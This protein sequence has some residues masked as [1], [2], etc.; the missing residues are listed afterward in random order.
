M[1]ARQQKTERNGAG[2]KP[3]RH[4]VFEPSPRWVRV[5]FNGEFVADSKQVMLLHEQGHLPVYYFPRGDVRMDLLTP[6]DHTT[7]CP[8]KGDASYWSV[9]VGEETVENALWGYPDP[10][11]DA[12]DLAD[13]VAF[14][15]EKMDCWFEE[16]TQVFVHPR[17]PYKRVDVCDS[18]RHVQVIVAGETV[19]DTRRPRL[20][21]ET[22]LPTRYY[23]PKVDARL[24]LLVPSQKR[25]RCP[26]KGQAG[27]YSVEVGETLV[28]D[29]VWTYPYPEAAVA[30]IQ[31]MLCFFNEKVEAIYIDGELEVKPETP[32]T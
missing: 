3:N 16:D 18:S 6:T 15:W 22:G 24:D 14:Y 23:I 21:F 27:Y 32:W 2:G 31:N 7:H 12:P 28:E 10:L 9:T 26:Y 17:D 11:P 29:I 25:T 20:L 1:T 4:I 19:A 30:A 8:Y 5:L 13:Y